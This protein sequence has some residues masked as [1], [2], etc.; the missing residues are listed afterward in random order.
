MKTYELSKEYK[1][2]IVPIVLFFLTVSSI[3]APP[4]TIFSH[5]LLITLT[6]V[7]WF[8]FLFTPYRIKIRDDNLI[9]FYC[10]LNRKTIQAS[11]IVSMTQG[12]HLLKIKHTKGN[13]LVSTLINNIS[14]L[15][16]NIIEL[17]KKV[18][19]VENKGHYHRFSG[20]FQKGNEKPW[21]LFSYIIISTLI[22]LTIIVWL[23]MN[24]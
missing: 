6:I 5:I 18:I 14:S 10:I 3:S 13:I 4:T 16:S 1:Y 19:A 7:L 17:N 8:L 15:K 11:D 23:G 24:Q 20:Y 12:I 9:N 22:G 2:F 21:Q